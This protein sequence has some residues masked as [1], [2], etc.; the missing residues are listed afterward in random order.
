MN[1]LPI[2]AFIAIGLAGPLAAQGLLADAGQNQQRLVQARAAHVAALKAH[3]KAAIA[4]T[5]QDLHAA[6]QAVNDDKSTAA[7]M[8]T[9]PAKGETRAEQMAI[10]EAKDRYRD[11]LVSGNKPEIART[12]AALGAAYHADWVARHAKKN[13]K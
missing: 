10:I 3:D 9:A 6:Y 2:F 11:A 12:H 13:S 8:A 4:R 5:E 7:E 1:R